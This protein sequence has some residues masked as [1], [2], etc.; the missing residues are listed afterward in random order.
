METQPQSWRLRVA[1]G[2]LLAALAAPALAAQTATTR[3][4]PA[5][6]A[7]A[8]QNAAANGTTTGPL[9]GETIER[10]RR[11]MFELLRATPRL[12]EILRNDSALLADQPLVERHN[13]QLARFLE[14][15]PEIPRNPEFYLFSNVGGM[16]LSQVRE[17]VESERERVM[18]RVVN[19]SGPVVVYLVVLGAGAWL[20]RVLMDNLRWKRVF[21]TQTEI[22]NKLLDKFSTNDELLAYVRSESGKRFLE[23]AMLPLNAE[24]PA[25]RSGIGRVLVPLQA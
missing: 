13:P 1:A 8:A 6:P 2:L 12:T 11:D 5:Q 25:Q 14:Q 21:N 16:H 24:A 20:L 17:N 19:E 18:M 9:D 4:K 22:Y 23:Q 15:H 3:A 10:N 7:A